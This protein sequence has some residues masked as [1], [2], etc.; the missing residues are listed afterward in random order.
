MIWPIEKGHRPLDIAVSIGTGYSG[1]TLSLPKWLDPANIQEAVK[2]YHDIVL[3][4]EKVWQSFKNES[5]KYRKHVHYRINVQL[6]RDYD[7]DD[8]K[9]MEKLR[10]L[11]KEYLNQKECDTMMDEVAFQLVANLLYFEPMERM[12][13]TTVN[14]REYIRGYIY[15]RLPT[16]GPEALKLISRI[17]GFFHQNKPNHPKN[18][19]HVFRQ[20]QTSR[21]GSLSKSWTSIKQDVMDGKTP[22]FAVP[23]AIGCNDDPSAEQCVYVNLLDGVKG[24]EKQLCRISGF[25][26][27]Y[28]G[29]HSILEKRRG[30]Q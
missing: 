27:S 4:S 3:N 23:Y 15:C 14:S 11:A 5:H 18:P 21:S 12:P 17:D 8:Y 24:T 30:L 10:R 1:S 16:G 9:A 20:W 6:E 13:P 29:L 28:N 22:C 26:I 2:A 19:E 25:P 7:L